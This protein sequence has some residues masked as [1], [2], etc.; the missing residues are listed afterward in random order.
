MAPTFTRFRQQ[1]LVICGLVSL[2]PFVFAIVATVATLPLAA[3]SWFLIEKPSQSLKSRLKRKRS[4][5][6]LAEA[7]QPA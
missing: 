1:L 3:L 6:E 2:N 4:G 5:S 7:E